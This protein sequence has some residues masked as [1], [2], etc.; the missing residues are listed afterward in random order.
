MDQQQKLT[1]EA[2]VPTSMPRRYLAQLCKHFQHKLPVDLAEDHGRITFSDGSCTLRTE[3]ETL[4]LRV[5]SEDAAA[6]A[7]LEDVVAR[8][9]LRFAFR[10]SPEVAWRR[11]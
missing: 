5:E 3:A 7:K 9:L 10:E 4:V 8:H 2:R 1:S 11:A 6:L